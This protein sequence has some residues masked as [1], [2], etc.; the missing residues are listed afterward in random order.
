MFSHAG[1]MIIAVAERAGHQ[2]LVL[3]LL[4]ALDI[5]PWC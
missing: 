2:T 3:R 5:R 1:M 4:K